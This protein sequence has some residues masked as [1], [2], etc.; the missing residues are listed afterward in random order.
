MFGLNAFAQ[1]PFNTLGVSPKILN[2]SVSENTSI[3]DTEAA[4]AAFYNPLSET[5]A[6][7]EAENSQFN[8]YEK[9]SG[10]SV[11]QRQ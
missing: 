11:I 2:L 3:T 10:N 9:Y 8:F 1:S 6:L 7:S 4:N 5:F